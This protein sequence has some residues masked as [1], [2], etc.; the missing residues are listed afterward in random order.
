MH[1]CEKIFSPSINWKVLVL[2][3]SCE[4][5]SAAM[6]KSEISL[7]I[8][9]LIK[10]NDARDAKLLL[11]KENHLRLEIL[12]YVVGTCCYAQF[13]NLLVYCLTFA[14]KHFYASIFQVIK[15]L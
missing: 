9:R 12:A 8:G 14:S 15:M 1:T 5:L 10:R 4:Y 2:T 6:S 3:R 7:K 11:R 13:A